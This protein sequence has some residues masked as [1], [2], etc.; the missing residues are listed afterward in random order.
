M[1]SHDQFSDAN[2]PPNPYV[3][4]Y[5]PAGLEQSSSG[6]AIAAFVVACS[7][8]L[9]MVV[10]N[11]AAGAAITDLEDARS[12]G[13]FD[14]TWAQVYDG[15]AL[16]LLPAFLV[17]W[18]VTCIWLVQ[19]RRQAQSINPDYPHARR[20]GWVWAGWL[21]PVV[22]LWFPFQVVRDIYAAASRFLRPSAL[23]WWWALWLVMLFANRILDRMM[24][25]QLDGLTFDSGPVVVL[26]VISAAAT[27]GALL[28]WGLTMRHIANALDRAD[29]APAVRR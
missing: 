8:G 15:T 17:A 14:D 18:A 20:V 19:V 2:Q 25:N 26:G 9:L 3:R 21:V 29:R 13:A 12:T 4:A 11:L 27:A 10:N 6:L 24:S 23:R 1:S 7:L 5:T 28:A 22:N 16:A